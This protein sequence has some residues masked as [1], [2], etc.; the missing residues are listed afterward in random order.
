MESIK[1]YT[2]DYEVIVIR[3][4]GSFAEN[5]NRGIATSSG[6]YIC[7]LNDDCIVTEGWLQPLIELM[8][9]NPKAGAV[10]PMM[11]YPNGKVQFGGMIFHSDYCGG[12]L[13]WGWNFDDKRLLKEPTQFQAT[14]F[15]CVLLRKEALW[16]TEYNHLEDYRLLD[17]WLDENYKIGGYED[18][19]WCFRAKLNGWEIWYQPKSKIWH[20]ENQA[21]NKMGK[22]RWNQSKNNRELFISRWKPYFD[23]GTFRIDDADFEGGK[24]NCFLCHHSLEDHIENSKEKLCHCGCLSYKVGFE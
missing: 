19:D 5:C 18:I 13:G 17:K 16:D 1:M 15:G 7:L 21:F 6:D 4:D 3:A 22:E 8:D 2:K 12:H 11:L 10:S 9:N 20:Y 24:V 14:T 23:N